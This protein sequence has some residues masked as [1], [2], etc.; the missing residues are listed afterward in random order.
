MIWK[1]FLFDRNEQDN[2]D[3]TNNVN[4]GFKSRKCPPQNSELDK[5]EADFL[6]MVHNIKFRNV[7]MK[8]QNKLK[9]DI[10]KI[11]KSTKA[12]IPADKTSNFYKLDQTQHDKL[13]RDSITT[14]YKKSSTDATNI[15]DS[16]A[17]SI[18]LLKGSTSTTG[19]HRINRKTASFYYPKRPTTP[20]AAS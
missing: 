3:A 19:P 17:K 1:A 12:F 4:F 9:E 5:F 18:A 15:I 7:K 11:K 6:D 8:F 16:Q 14:T 20:Y 13:P 2:N 10:S